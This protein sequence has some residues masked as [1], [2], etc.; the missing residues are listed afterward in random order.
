M[1]PYFVGIDLPTSIKQHLAQL[2]FGLPNVRWT[3]L[4]NFHVTL[5]YFGRIND[6][7][8]SD[9]KE[10]LAKIEFPSFTFMLKGVDHFHSH[11]HGVLWVGTSASETVVKFKKEIDV[12]L[13]EL[14]IIPD[15]RTYVPHVTLGRYEKLN[16]ARLADYLMTHRFFESLE[17]T[18]SHFH[19]FRSRQTPK[20][21][22][23]EKMAEYP[24]ILEK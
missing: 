23:Y 22:F 3:E 18:A 11:R 19:L 6:P 8:I 13:K 9:I 1:D 7:L 21:V 14:E 20:R 16:A 17:M 10:A 4:E 15:E 5:R 12:A 2:C 24:F